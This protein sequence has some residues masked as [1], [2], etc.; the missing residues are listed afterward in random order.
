LLDN[1]IVLSQGRP[2]YAGNARACPA[3]LEAL[4]HPIP[5]HFNPFEHIIGLSSIDSRSPEREVESQAQL[6]I[7]RTAWAAKSA[8]IYAVKQSDHSATQTNGASSPTSTKLLPRQRSRCSALQRIQ[9]LTHRTWK[10]TYRDRL[11]ATASI[12]EAIV[13]G[14]I[15]GWTF[16][17]V[18]SDLS[19]I[20]TRE[21][22]LWAATTMQSYL[23]LIM[24]TYRL[25]IDIQVFDRERKEG[26]SSATA[27]VA[28][29]RLSRLLLEDIP[30]PFLYSTIFY[31]MAGFRHQA[32]QYLVFFGVGLLLH[33]AAVNLATLCVALNRHFMVASLIANCAFTIQSLAGGFFVNTAEISVWL[34]WT[35]WTAYTVSFLRC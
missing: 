17:Q 15:T 20:R 2:V 33:F 34:R 8:Q 16:Y 18:P 31:F 23:V 9:I 4:G 5:E 28:S 11:G 19:G 35:K 13:L 6:A 10:V 7:L 21:G 12:I 25:T 30:V 1:L 27:F 22:A 3:Y 29:R 14:L 26:V 32:D 24:E